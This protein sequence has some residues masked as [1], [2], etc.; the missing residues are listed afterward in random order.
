MS[1]TLNA[2]SEAWK[3]ASYADCFNHEKA[4]GDGPCEIKNKLATR[5][6]LFVREL[7]IL[8]AKFDAQ[9]LTTDAR[10]EDKFISKVQQTLNVICACGIMETIFYLPNHFRQ[11]ILVNSSSL[12]F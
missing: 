5:M 11:T 7:G 1:Q 8:R 6:R 10:M 12:N 9:V 3:R 2:V 4:R